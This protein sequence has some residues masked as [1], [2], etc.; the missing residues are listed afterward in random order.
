MRLGASGKH[1]LCPKTIAPLQPRRRPPTVST[2]PPS[3]FDGLSLK[4]SVPL[5]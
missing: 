5:L 3:P 2:I 1:V 4:T